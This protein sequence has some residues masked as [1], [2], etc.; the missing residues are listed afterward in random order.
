[1]QAYDFK[2][3][4]WRVEISTEIL[5]NFQ[6]ESYKKCHLFGGTFLWAFPS[7]RLGRVLLACARSAH[8]AAYASRHI[9]ATPPNAKQ[10]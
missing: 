9:R 1:M 3:E 5:E 10:A 7:L 8:R 6:K 2:N 4:S